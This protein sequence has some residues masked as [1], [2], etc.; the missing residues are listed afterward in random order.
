MEDSS[1]KHEGKTIISKRGRRRLRY[2]IYQAALV[3]I[4]QNE[5]FREVY[6][7][8]LTREV[9]PLKKMQALMAVACKFLRVLYAIVT[10]GTAYAP[11]RILG[12][13]RRP[14]KKTA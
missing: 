11:G 8:Y 13:I 12:D 1:G 3:L 2:H 5:E 7:Y 6:E 9:N 10:K 4:A 14:E